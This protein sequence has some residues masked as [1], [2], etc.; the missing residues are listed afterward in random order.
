MEEIAV[1]EQ[2][3]AARLHMNDLIKRIKDKKINKCKF[4]HFAFPF[5]QRTYFVSTTL[6]M[7][8]RRTSYEL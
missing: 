6:E 3:C 5:S 4:K 1:R 2:L 7:M 8:S